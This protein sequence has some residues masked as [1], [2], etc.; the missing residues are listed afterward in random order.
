MEWGANMFLKK[1]K[2]ILRKYS[3]ELNDFEQ[4]CLINFVIE[5]ILYIKDQIYRCTSPI[6]LERLIEEKYAFMKLSIQLGFNIYLEE[7][8]MRNPLHQEVN[9]YLNIGREDNDEL[10][11]EMQVEQETELVNDGMVVEI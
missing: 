1:K 5:K 7:F 2:E 9:Y 10:E 6:T 8:Q 4:V 3:I 11:D